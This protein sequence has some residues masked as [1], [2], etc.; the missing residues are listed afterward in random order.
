MVNRINIITGKLQHLIVCNLAP[1][2]V[3]RA[4][5][6]VEDSWT[7]LIKPPNTD[8]ITLTSTMFAMAQAVR[9][10][11]LLETFGYTAQ[12]FKEHNAVSASTNNN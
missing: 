9:S 10:A 12:Q 5:S 3:H 4:A 8:N 2:T 11:S 6:V 1:R 7:W